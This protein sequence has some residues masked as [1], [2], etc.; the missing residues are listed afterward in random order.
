MYE[1]L[2]SENYTFEVTQEGNSC[3]VQVYDSKTSKKTSFFLANAVKESV[4]R[5]M[6][7]LTDNHLSDY[8]KKV[9]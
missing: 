7:T 5:H 9:K 2:S 4:E 1:K 3:N 8:F 6:N